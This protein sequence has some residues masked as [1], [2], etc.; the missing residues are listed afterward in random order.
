MPGLQYKMAVQMT[1][2][3]ASSLMGR[4][5]ELVDRVIPP[6]ARQEFVKN[7]RAFARQQPLLASFLAVQI[8]LSAL[9]LLLFVSFSVATLLVVLV[10]AVA[11]AGF[12]IGAALLVLVPTLFTVFFAGLFLWAWAV[13]TYVFF[14]LASRLTGRAR[15]AA[16][17]YQPIEST[18]KAA[19]NMA[20]Q[21]KPIE[22]TKKTVGDKMDAL[23]K[24][25]SRVT[26]KVSA[27]LDGFTANRTA[28][29]DGQSQSEP[30]PGVPD[31]VKKSLNEA[32]ASPEAAANPEAVEEKKAVEQ[33][34]VG[35]FGEE[36]S[37]QDDQGQTNGY[38]NG[39]NVSA[40]DSFV[41]QK[42][43]PEGV[44]DDEAYYGHSVP[45]PGQQRMMADELKY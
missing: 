20:D 45:A 29:Q 37:L 17:Q 6:D 34:I 9:P 13:G 22:S 11:F 31:V 4:V 10:T 5:Q 33:D 21:Y 1:K 8:V 44:Q 35:A 43:A 36:D 14:R 32:Q 38:Y 18:K 30:A 28:G 26:S 41:P 19:R 24:A 25:S 12:W 42:Q 2:E 7:S 16:Q 15:N 23:S 27:T 40:N 39:D 3:K